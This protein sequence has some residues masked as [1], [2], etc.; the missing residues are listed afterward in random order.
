MVT[1]KRCEVA[2]M[3]HVMAKLRGQD[4]REAAVVKPSA[5]SK[6]LEGEI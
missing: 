6:R 2:I 5:E 3:D 4:P 1:H